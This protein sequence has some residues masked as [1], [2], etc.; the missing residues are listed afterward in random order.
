MP[1]YWAEIEMSVK[2]NI[3][4]Q[5]IKLYNLVQYIVYFNT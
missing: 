1:N 4:K 2:I 5:G 3:D